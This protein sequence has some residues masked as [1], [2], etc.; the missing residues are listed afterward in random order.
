VQGARFDAHPLRDFAVES[1][2]IAATAVKQFAI[3]V[4]LTLPLLVMLLMFSAS[5]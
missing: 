4:L 2:R 5:I 3:A 1:R